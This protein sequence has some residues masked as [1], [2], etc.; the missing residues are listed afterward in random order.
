MQVESAL[1]GVAIGAYFPTA[2]SERPRRLCRQSVVAAC[3]TSATASGLSARP[4]PT[5][6]F[7]CGDQVAAV[8]AARANYDQYV[9]TYRETVLSSFQQVEDQLLAL[10]VLQKEAEF[11]T[12]AVKSA[13]MAADVALNE[14]NAGT[15]AYTTVVTAVPDSADE[16]AIRADH[17]AES[18][19]RERH[20]DRGAR[21]RMGYIAAVQMNKL[22]RLS[23]AI[24]DFRGSRGSRCISLSASRPLVGVEPGAGR[25]ELR[26]RFV[27]G[28]DL[29][30]DVAPDGGADLFAIHRGG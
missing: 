23:S 17:P 26:G 9:A 15:V 19:G 12:Q 16:S 29:R 3:S 25:L 4:R 18:A 27:P 2:Q 1:I 11:Q 13:Q 20:A 22:A 7:E 28:A 14:F 30:L 24:L 6:C 8:A 10:R 21:R 5:P